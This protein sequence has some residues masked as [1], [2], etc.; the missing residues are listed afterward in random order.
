MPKPIYCPLI[1]NK[2]ANESTFVLKEQQGGNI[3]INLIMS[4]KKNT[5]VLHRSYKMLRP[6][7][8]ALQTNNERNLEFLINVGP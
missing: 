4:I 2:V 7:T 3:I 8:F 6:R 1:P 5:M